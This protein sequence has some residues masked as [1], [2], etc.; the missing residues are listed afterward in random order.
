MNVVITGTSKGI[1]LEL[2]KQALEK[3]YKVLALARKPHESSGLVELQKKHSSL[4]ELAAL[5]VA[6]RDASDRMKDLTKKFSSIDILINNAGIYRGDDTAEEFLESFRVNSVAPLFM[7]RS[8]FS[9]LK[10]SAT[11][12]VCHIT[13]LMGSITDNDSGGSYSY[14]ASKAALNMI[15]KSLSRN[16]AWL[17]AIVV[18]PGWVKTDMGGAAAPTEVHESGSGIWKV[19][20][21]VKPTD[22]GSFYDFEGDSLPW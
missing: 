21:K 3:G 11:P 22:S 15:N 6:D 1:G 19:I 17:T 4:L 7:T 10:E 8:L 16:E 12:K 9:K 13:S 5:D 20:E 18:H 14:R 2:T